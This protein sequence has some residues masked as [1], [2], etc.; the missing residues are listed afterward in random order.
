MHFCPFSVACRGLF[1]NTQCFSIV[2]RTYTTRRSMSSRGRKARS[3]HYIG[4]AGTAIGPINGVDRAEA[5][6]VVGGSSDA[7]GLCLPCV[8]M[9]VASVGVCEAMVADGAS[10]LQALKQG[11]EW[12]TSAQVYIYYIIINN[13]RNGRK[14]TPRGSLVTHHTFIE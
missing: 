3:M 8:D 5:I 6:G 10:F 12:C 9:G 1:P 7:C 11:K 4:S 2:A 14:G 13:N